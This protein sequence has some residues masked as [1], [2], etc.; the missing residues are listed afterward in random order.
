MSFPISDNILTAYCLRRCC[1]RQ[2]LR[3]VFPSVDTRNLI[4]QTRLEPWVLPS[5]IRQYKRARMLY[6][7]ASL[8]SVF[9]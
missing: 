2:G 6:L 9:Q 3:W 4:T 8:Q 1:A 7:S 5:V